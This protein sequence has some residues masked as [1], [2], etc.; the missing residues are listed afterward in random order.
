MFRFNTYLSFL[1]LLSCLAAGMS[2][3][4][5][6]DDRQPSGQYIAD[7]LPEKL[8]SCLYQDAE[9]YLWAGSQ[10]G[11]HPYDGVAFRTFS[12]RSS[13]STSLSQD[14][15]WAICEEKAGYLW[16][17][18]ERGLNRY[19]KNKEQFELLGT[20]N[21]KI[22]REKITAICE[23][24]DR[25]LWIGTEA[26]LFQLDKNNFELIPFD[27]GEL[28]ASASI[29]VIM[30]DR[31]QNLWI[32][33]ETRGV[34][35]LSAGGKALQQFSQEVD[36]MQSN[37]INQIIETPSGQLYVATD[38][39]FAIFE[40]ETQSFRL[41]DLKGPLGESLSRSEV[42]AIAADEAGNLWLGT[43][44]NGLFYFEVER[45]ILM[46][47]SPF[48][49]STASPTGDP[50]TSLLIDR[51]GLL[52]IGTY[53]GGLHAFLSKDQQFNIFAQAEASSA[54]VYA[55]HEDMEQQLWLGK[56][57]GLEVYDANGNLVQEAEDEVAAILPDHQGN[58]WLG[59]IGSGLLKWT[60]GTAWPPMEVVVELPPND[61]SLVGGINALLED[62]QHQLWIGTLEGVVVIDETGQLKDRFKTE[63]TDS[64]SLSNNEVHVLFGEKNGTI[65]VGTDEGLSYYDDGFF[66][67]NINSEAGAV[68]RKSAVY[69]IEQSPDGAFWIATSEG[70]VQIAP[71][72]QAA[73][74]FSSNNP[75]VS[76]QLYGLLFDATGDLWAS[77]AKGIWRV[78]TA[79]FSEEIS[80][81]SYLAT[82]GQLPCDVFNIGAHFK[83]Q[84]DRL[85]FGCK[86]EA[87]WFRPREVW[88]NEYRP[89]AIINSFQIGLEEVDF[90]DPE[91]PLKQHISQ[92]DRIVLE[93]GL[94]RIT[95]GFTALNFIRPDA[96]SFRYRM[97]KV[98]K[99]WIYDR[100][101]RIA[102]YPLSSG[103]YVFRLQAANNEGIWNNEET[104]L[105][106]IIQ[107]PFTQTIWFFL[108]CLVILAIAVFAFVR[109]RTRQLEQ[110]Q[111]RLEV[112]VA[113]RTEEVN[114]KNEALEQT[115]EELKEAQTQLVEQEKM[116]SLGQLTAG[117]AHEINNPITFV[118]GNITP[119]KRDIDEM[120]EILKGYEE[121]V[122]AQGL[123][124]K[125][126]RINQLKDQLD[127]D[128]LLEEIKQ[129]LEGITEGAE[130]TA[131]IVRGL[132]NFSRLDEDVLKLANVNQGI[133]ST[134][135][136]LRSELKDRVE[137]VKDMPGMPDILCYPGKLNGVYMNILTNAMQ[138]IDGPGKIYI[139]TRHLGDKVTISIRDTGKGMP[140]EVQKRIFEPF[141]TTKDVGFGTGLGLSI[142][143]G[144]IEMHKGKISVKSKPGEGTE[145]LIELPV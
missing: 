112:K 114:K 113:E 119:L 122:K 104:R 101:N 130:R 10:D 66:K 82:D 78:K 45:S 57:D 142:T 12:H 40:P 1:C 86:G 21:G 25:R 125:F 137:I 47:I 35:R 26:G 133:E 143:Y 135:L 128:F 127:Y 69:D 9:G 41:P 121:E 7:F 56:A 14:F 50:I 88:Q 17:G 109:F 34:F 141:F 28:N 30:E 79:P 38:A 63:R 36:G 83:T 24:A 15:V 16:I 124:A 70:L 118:S 123:E 99:D 134:L 27:L 18:T 92:T 144:A 53:L 105:E 131:E 96:N 49:A 13:D 60:A 73:R 80:L 72:K 19:D 54:E 120:M 29:K 55:V 74:L 71:D 64:L 136:L 98:D 106:I 117:V 132:R 110:T 61:F 58:I 107:R 44:D 8:I 75:E 23:D 3:A 139:T 67:L 85:I 4:M 37:S 33:T 81:V 32:G 111:R 65:W 48:L 42:E 20:L 90:R 84:D 31:A 76:S 89:P 59:T 103:S 11:L 2:M 94:Y 87:V 145:F 95:L 5:A 39:S 140:E 51:S 93:P 77:S 91:S 52:W 108:I 43:F 129:L 6:Q 62:E 116:A 115:L 138:A 46:K 68:L 102:E 22:F 126:K 97:D 100:G